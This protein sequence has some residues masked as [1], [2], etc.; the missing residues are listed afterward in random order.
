MLVM[1]ENIIVNN[2]YDLKEISTSNW[3]SKLGIIPQEIHIFN[4]NILYNIVLEETFDSDH[5]EKIIIKYNLSDFLQI[6]PNGLYTLVGEE[7]INLSGGQ[8]Q[9]IGLLRALYKDPQFYILDEPTSALD[10]KSEQLVVNILKELKK[11]AIVLLITHHLPNFNFLADNIYK[12]SSNK[13]VEKAEL[14]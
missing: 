4:G 11:E 12:L 5:L 1:R 9:I 10:K 13:I 3:R 14:I 6:F 7:G 8:K 2:K